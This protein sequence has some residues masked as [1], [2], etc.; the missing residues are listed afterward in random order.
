M[1]ILSFPKN[2]AG[3]PGW[4]SRPPV[5]V[6]SSEP[7]NRL[8]GK[9]LTRPALALLQAA[10]FSAVPAMLA[11]TP[12][13]A[14]T[15]TAPTSNEGSPT[16]A[17]AADQKLFTRP[18]APAS[19]TI[20]FRY[21]STVAPQ[22]AAHRPNMVKVTAIGKEA[23]ETIHYP[24]RTS[25]IWR[26]EGHV[27]VSEAGSEH[28]SIRVAQPNFSGV[29]GNGDQITGVERG[30]N[31]EFTAV[32]NGVLITGKLAAETPDWVEFKEFDWVT[33]ELLKGK[34]ELSG[35]KLLVYAE[36]EPEPQTQSAAA[37]S[38]KGRAPAQAQAA[39][40]YPAGPLGG[41]PLK[42]GIRVAAIEEATKTPRYLQV[43]EDIQI[44]AFSKPQQTKL[45]LPAKITALVAKPAP[46]PEGAKPVSLV[47]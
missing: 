42:P 35:E 2:P 25:E 11:Q 9:S 46:P 18:A 26:A 27:I 28:A 13:P 10:L 23:V 1:A 3:L 7:R 32:V 36:M 41:L 37:P 38:G 5:S 20:T 43:G 31:G 34:I 44:Y 29:G 47:P 14:P 21:G 39:P 24:E 16:A 4:T 33:P 19:W 17:V 22:Q 12:A 40:K 45:D 6:P 15:Q 30:K 8:S